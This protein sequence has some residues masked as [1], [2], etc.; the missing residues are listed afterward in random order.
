[1]TRHFNYHPCWHSGNNQSVGSSVPVVSRWLGP[2]SRTFL[3]VAS[4]V[5]TW[6]IVAFL[7]SALPHG[8]YHGESSTCVQSVLM[9]RI[10]HPQC[11]VLSACLYYKVQ[12]NFILVNRCLL[13]TFTL[14]IK[15]IKTK[16]SPL[17]SSLYFHV[18][19]YGLSLEN[20]H[21]NSWSASHD[22]WCTGTL[23]NRIITAQWEGMRDVGSVGY[24][25]ALL[26]PCPTIRVSS[27]SNCYRSTHSISKWIFRNLAL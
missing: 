7:R 8:S 17:I 18:F 20:F 24:E 25:L 27:Y 5:V 4:M 13:T 3:E 2:E 9:A 12:L 15:T 22:N 11:E 6:S 1:M 14:T 21:I 23:L 26:P 16:S 19:W 10:I